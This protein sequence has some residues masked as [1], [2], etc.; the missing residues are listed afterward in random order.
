MNN[1][2]CNITYRRKLR[3]SYQ[4]I[5]FEKGKLK[6]HELEMLRRNHLSGFLP[7]EFMLADGKG[8]FWYNITGLQSLED[9][10]K[11]GHF[12]EDTLR[13]LVESLDRIIQTVEQYALREE[14]IRM[15]EIFFSPDG[16]KVYFGYLPIK[17]GEELSA[18]EKLMQILDRLMKE[19][20]YRDNDY[21]TYL[22]RLYEAMGRENAGIGTLLDI[23]VRTQKNTLEE[24]EPVK[25][26]IR[27]EAEVQQETIPE[28]VK[29]SIKEKMK[30]R[31]LDQVWAVKKKIRRY[32]DFKSEKREEVTLIRPEDTKEENRNTQFLGSGEEIVGRIRFA[33]PERESMPLT[34]SRYVVGKRKEYADLVVDDAS[35]S[36]VHALIVREEDG[37][38]LEDLNSLNGTFL[39]GSL[40]E[41]KEKVRLR[42]RDEIGVGN[43]TLIFEES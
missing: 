36:R 35:V 31:Y 17:T 7:V 38:Y 18:R 5:T 23:S 16:E 1:T 29:E 32:T 8:Q 10:K 12:Q 2:D 42:S 43:S 11:A 21:V 22:F 24:R 20:D 40:L 9:L 19:A 30:N 3:E 14:A 25:Q 39:N 34:R 15:D 33:D 4:V 27:T 6:I 13:N 26:E 37:Y 41:L 28:R